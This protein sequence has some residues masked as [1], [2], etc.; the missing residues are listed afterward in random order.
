MSEH[1][2]YYSI[3]N[4]LIGLSLNQLQC[5]L[6]KIMINFISLLRKIDITHSTSVYTPVEMQ[7]P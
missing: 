2:I 4:T 7:D 1:F 6:R 5:E 3:T